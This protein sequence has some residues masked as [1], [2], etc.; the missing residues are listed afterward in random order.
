MK[1]N[2]QKIPHNPSNTSLVKSKFSHVLHPYFVYLKK[3]AV[4]IT[5]L[6]QH[7]ARSERQLV[8][9]DEK[10]GAQ[11][12]AVCIGRYIFWYV[13]VKYKKCVTREKAQTTLQVVLNRTMAFHA[14]RL[15]WACS[16]RK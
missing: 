16:A 1:Q 15:L 3:F 12:L 8:T 9:G 11:E 2:S 7:H 4:S 6:T 14:A 13:F 10:C 5:Y